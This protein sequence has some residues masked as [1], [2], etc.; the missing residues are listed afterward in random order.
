[1]A[2]LSAEV[3]LPTSLAT[4]ALV[5]AIYNSALPSLADVRSAPQDDAVVNS[6]ERTAAWTAAGVVGGISLISHDPNVFILGS[7]MI[8]TLS[9]WHRHANQVNPDNNKAATT[10]P[11]RTPD[12]YQAGSAS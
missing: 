4:A 1:M 12:M 5:W 7:A 6:S 11:V 8:I 10:N 9:W 3:S 2:G